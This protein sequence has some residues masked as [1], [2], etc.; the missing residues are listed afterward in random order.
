MEH[1]LQGQLASFR[2]P[3]ILTFLNLSRKTGALTLTNRA[4]TVI[5]HLN[6]GA[7][8]FASSNQKRFRLGK[9]LQRKKRIKPDEARW[10]E[11]IMLQQREKFGHVAVEKNILTG[12]EL[13]DFLKIQVSEILYDTFVWTEGAFHFQDDQ[14]LPDYAVTISVDLSNLIM[15]GARRIDEWDRCQQLLPSPEMVFRVIAA[16]EIQERITLSLAEWKILFLIDGRR[17][18]SDLCEQSEEEALEVYRVVY[19]LYANKLIEAVPEGELLGA[20]LLRMEEESSNMIPKGEVT[21]GALPDDTPLL[22]SPDAT[23]TF[24][25]VMRVT[26]ARLTVKE[27]GDVFQLDGPE[28]LIGRTASSHIRLTDPSVSGIHARVYRGPEGYVLED[29]NSRNGT[30]V[31]E[32]R[33]EQKLLK[34]DD[35]IRLGNS[36]LVYHIVADLK[37]A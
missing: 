8:V 23:L 12:E 21:T 6:A 20:A 13:Q 25:D 3:D 1:S 15:E 32:D 17:S 7:I 37:R 24:R 4:R 35:L 18:L 9:V 30:F 26:L 29:L 31:N 28:Y 27:T 16:P 36:E 33:I 11:S 22:I 34:E 2:L 10:I 5:I 19:G 14:P